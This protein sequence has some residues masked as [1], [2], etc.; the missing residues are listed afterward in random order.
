MTVGAALSRSV[1]TGNGSTTEFPFNAPV[2]AATEIKVYTVVIATGVQTLQTK[3]GS[4]TYDY[5]VAINASTNYATVTVNTALPDT[6]K[7]VIMRNVPLTQ[8]TDYV[9]G[10]AFG[11]ETH[12]AALDK[13]TMIAAQISEVADRSIKVQETSATTNIT[14]AELVADKVLKVNSDGDGI[15]MGPTTANLDTLA[16]ITSDITTVAGISSNVTSVAGNATNIN[17]VAADATDIGAVAGKATEIG[18]L[19]TAD[20]VADLAI[21]GTTDIVSDMNT[22]GTSDN[23]TNMDTL[24]GIASNITTVAGISSNVTTVAGIS[25]NVTTVAGVAS[26]V[27]TVAGV[28]SNVTTVAGIAANVTTV[29]SNVSGINDFAARYRV[30]AGDPGS[31]NDAGDLNFNTSS[32]QLKYWTGSAWSVVANTDT[33][34]AI[35]ANDTTPDLLINKLTAGTNISLTETNDGGDETITITNTSTGETK[36]TIS[37][38]S[39]DTIPNTAT[40][41]VITGTNYVVT[42]NVEFIASTGVITLPNSIVRDSATQLTVNVTLPTDGTY[43][44]RVENPDGLAVR[45]GS[46][47]LTVSDAPTWSTAAGSL[48]EVAAGASVSLDVDA[49]SDS[50]VAFSETTSVLTSNSNTPASTMNLTLNSSTGAITGTAPSPSSETTYNFTLRATDAES[51][52]ADRAF[53]ITI[54]VGMNNS[55]CFSH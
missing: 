37:S 3:D 12:E 51:Q 15:E 34:V 17:A 50:T 46:A 32:N 39:P 18:R 20:A 43:F 1:S 42:P 4:G 6:H 27:T 38:I 5:S 7:I 41:I 55:G 33:N 49:T 53:S 31:D 11:A 45:S 23:V 8:E 2:A 36:P 35:S 22:L 14:C 13:L 52:T 54:S 26:N 28:S 40:N 19:G 25:S 29:A 21:L 9:E 24:A 30:T 10:D 48:G 44:I 16:G 47:I